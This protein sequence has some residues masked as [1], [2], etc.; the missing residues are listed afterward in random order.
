MGSEVRVM[1]IGAQRITV[2]TVML[3]AFAFLITS[4][5]GAP[6]RTKV[7]PVNGTIEA[8]AMDGPRV[9]YDV[10]HAIGKNEV[11]VWDVNTGKA[12]KVSGKFTA[13]ADVTSTGRGV[14]ELAIAG[15]RVVWI[16]NH[17]GLTESDD[18]LCGSWL[19]KPKEQ[20]LATAVRTGDIDGVLTGKWIGGLVGSV[21]LVAVNRWTTDST[22][23]V[24]KGGLD[25]IGAVRLTRVASGPDTLWA[26]SADTFPA[27]IAVAHADGT[28]AIFSATGRKRLTM[29]PSST[30]RVALHRE[31]LVVMT[32]ARTLEVYDTRT[33]NLVKTWPLKSPL[34]PEA[35]GGELDV[36][37]N[38]A[39]YTVGRELRVLSLRTGKDRVLAKRSRAIRFA[40]IE[41][42]GAVFVAGEMLVY[43]PFARVAA[44][45]S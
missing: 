45:L 12:T 39:L 30:R 25:R 40:Q 8:L 33:G 29:T 42:P 17:G 5:T 11:V 22:G 2:P 38:I 34:P 44:V 7:R 31:R 4:A 18:Y 36:E 28:V 10:R 15:P 27:R 24:T 16:V 20:K 21:G 3:A 13:A 35:Q 1:K 32:K 41:S 6:T 26:Q 43:V 14:S 37:G 19:V 9:A 23:A